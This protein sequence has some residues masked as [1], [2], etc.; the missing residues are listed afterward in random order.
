MISSPADSTKKPGGPHRKP[1]ADVYTVFLILALSAILLAIVFL[2][3]ENERYDW[4]YEGGPTASAVGLSHLAPQ[5]NPFTALASTDAPTIL[6]LFQLR[7]G[8]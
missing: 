8:G 2:Y 7:S 1:R 5:P 6:P 4:D 3:F